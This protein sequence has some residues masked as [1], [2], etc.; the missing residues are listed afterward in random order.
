[1]KRFVSGIL[2]IALFIGSEISVSAISDDGYKRHS[3]HRSNYH[4]RNSN[5]GFRLKMGEKLVS[6][7]D[8]FKLGRD[9]GEYLV[10][11][12]NKKVTNLLKR[13]SDGSLK[14]VQN[15]ANDMLGCTKAI[16]TVIFDLMTIP[17]AAAV[18]TEAIAECGLELVVGLIVS[19]YLGKPVTIPAVVMA[20]IDHIQTYASIP[21]ECFGL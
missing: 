6:V 12:S 8:Y 21:S 4:H 7:Q 18:I 5:T 16:A 17:A 10:L 14:P 3:I 19:Y 15:S 13:A 2:S 9:T 20:V 1:M 11:D